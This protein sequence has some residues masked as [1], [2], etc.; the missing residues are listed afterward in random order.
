MCETTRYSEH[1][2]NSMSDIKLQNGKQ[3]NVG[4]MNGYELIVRP[5]L[6]LKIYNRLK[7]MQ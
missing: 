3:K 4:T 5:L 7:C 2:N 6:N 1:N